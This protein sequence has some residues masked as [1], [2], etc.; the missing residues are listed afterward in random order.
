MKDVSSFNLP[1]TTPGK[2]P[3]LV[4]HIEGDHLKEAFVVGD[5]GVVIF[6]QAKNV[7]DAAIVLLAVYYLAHLSYPRV[8]SQALGFLQHFL[9]GEPYTGTTL[10][11]Q[12]YLISYA[13]SKPWTEY[14]F[15]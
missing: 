5:D 8:Y 12:A 3:Y 4:L 7:L 10:D 13:D 11:L 14:H 1:A 9:I 6:T 15:R 2:A